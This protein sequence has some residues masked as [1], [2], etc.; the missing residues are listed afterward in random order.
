VEEELRKKFVSEIEPP[1]TTLLF[2]DEHRHMR[3]QRSPPDS[4][5][6]GVTDISREAGRSTH[7]NAEASKTAKEMDLALEDL[8]YWADKLKDD[9]R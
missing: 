1:E 7:W 8:H 9:E 3:R 2:A 4:A 5:T 6:A